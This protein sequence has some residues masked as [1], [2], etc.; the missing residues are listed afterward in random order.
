LKKV[1]FIFFLFLIPALSF[2]QAKIASID[3]RGNDFFSS[4]TLQDYMVLKRDRDFNSF[5]FDADL[6]AIRS[7]YKTNGFLFAKIDSMSIRYNYD[8]SLVDLS[9]IINEGEQ[10]K[11]GKIELS[12]N[13]VV[14]DAEILSQL[15]TKPDDVLDERVLDD[16]IIN[17]LNY[18][19]QKGLPFVKASVEDV[20]VYDDDG[21]KYLRINLQIEENS[22][23]KIQ[24]IKIT[25]NEVTSRDVILREI[26]LDTSDYVTSEMLEDIKLRLEKLNVFDFVDNPK[27]YINKKQN[28]TGLLIQVREGNNNTFDGIIG[29][30]PPPSENE[31]G[32]FTGLVNVSFRNL[33]GT[34]RRLHLRW[35]QEVRETQ[36]L[37]FKI[38]EPYLLSSPVSVDLGFLQRIQD[39]TYTRRRIDV[40]AGLPISQRFL[41]SALGGYDRIIPAEENRNSFIIADS[42]IFSTGIELRYDT[43]DNIYFPTSGNLIKTSY[44]YGDKK[45]FNIAELDTL[46]FKENYSIQRY[47]GELDVF[48]SFFKRTS[49]LLKLFGGEVRGEKIE[50]SELFRIGGNKSIRGYRE[51]QFLA[52]RLFYGN[53]EMRFAISRRSFFY[54]F[55]DAGYYQRV[56][57]DI[58]NIPEQKGF[59]FGY[60]I[61]LRLETNLGL[62]GVSYALGKGD[63]P[64]DGKINFG[65][66][67]DF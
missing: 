52:S 1:F 14:T 35:Q 64:L 4:R 25:G 5:Q 51:E 33:F 2:G 61:G 8:S 53:L 32:Y 20:S 29:Y 27:I 62:I 10:V 38:G 55:Y 31:N 45:I 26:K 56:A 59:L 58:N 36:E 48:Y 15:E 46:G 39:T 28:K 9:I 13:K 44:T 30:V 67:T 18:Y 19:Q 41:I 50:E 40:V 63:S 43:R 11:V 3:F 65:L 12:G 21:K 7:R 6:K 37:E 22:R 16:D 17:L 66:I 57:D 42:R 60:G 24:E 23:I 54:G 49:T 34:A 47:T